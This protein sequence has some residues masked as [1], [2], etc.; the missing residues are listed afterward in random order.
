MFARGI[1]VHAFTRIYFD[2]EAANRN[3]PVLMSIEDEVLS[4]V[5]PDEEENRRIHEAVDRLKELIVQA[6]DF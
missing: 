2:D 5:K 3:D 4:R 6:P 1:L